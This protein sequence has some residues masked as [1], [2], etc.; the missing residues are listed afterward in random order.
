MDILG[1]SS[2]TRGSL[3]RKGHLLTVHI[4][5]SIIARYH[6][7]GK[8]FPLLLRHQN[9][10]AVMWTQMASVTLC[11]LD[12]QHATWMFTSSVWSTSPA[13]A[14]WITQRR[15]G[16]FIWRPR[17]PM[18]SS[19]SR[20]RHHLGEWLLG[21]GQGDGKTGESKLSGHLPLIN[22]MSYENALHTKIS[23]YSNAVRSLNQPADLG[24]LTARSPFS[25]CHAWDRATNWSN[26]YC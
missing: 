8:S 4:T 26:C 25:S 17:S 10:K 21:K 23:K 20:V 24:V 22:N 13:S 3:C 12:S 19:T 9:M 2:L 7:R 18:K 14:E 1:V 16:G 11:F 15:G 6:L 5:R